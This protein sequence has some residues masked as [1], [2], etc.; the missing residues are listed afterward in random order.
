MCGA[1][2]EESKIDP[3][4]EYIKRFPTKLHKIL[5]DSDKRTRFFESISEKYEDI[6]VYRGLHRED[7]IDRDDF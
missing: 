6:V 7:K 4:E 2:C 5:E 3:L 1:E